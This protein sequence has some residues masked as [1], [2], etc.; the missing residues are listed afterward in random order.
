MKSPVQLSGA[1]RRLGLEPHRLVGACIAALGLAL[2]APV[3]AAPTNADC[4][5]CHDDA[6]LKKA[7]GTLVSATHQALAS[8]VHGTKAKD[9]V[10]CVGCHNDVGAAW[11][12]PHKT[13]PAPATCIGCHKDMAAK[14]PFHPQMVEDPAVIA[15]QDCHGGHDVVPVKDAAFKF[16]RA[17]QAEAC[18][19]CHESMRDDFK[20]SEHFKVGDGGGKEAPG[21]VA[22]HSLALVTAPQ[23]SKTAALKQNQVRICLGCHLD[24][25]EVRARVI[26]SAGFIREYEES[27]HGRALAA[28][29]EKAPACSDCHG[30]HDIKKAR[31]D[32]SKVNRFHMQEAC[33]ECHKEVAAA[34]Q[35]SVHG[36]ALAKGMKDAPTC[37]TCHGEHDIKKKGDPAS[38]VASA[39]LSAK[40]CAPCH[41][42]LQLAA[43]FSIPADRFQTFEDSFHGMA[44]RGGAAKVANCASCHGAHDIKPSSDP[45]SSVSK[46][47]LAATCGKCHPGANERFG[48]G[49]MHVTTS[50]QQPVLFW[51]SLIYILLIVFVIGAMAA[52][53]AI[54]FWRKSKNMMAVRRGEHEEPPAVH[55][56]YLRM[57]AG[58]RVQHIGLAVSFI[59]LVITG[60]MVRF[61]ES[62][63][64]AYIRRMSPA[65]FDL[66]AIAHR[67][68]AVVMLLTS[69]WHLGYI[70][71]TRRGHEFVRD[72]LPGMR[73]VREALLM[74]VYNL[75]WSHERPK[76]GRFCYVEK[77]EYW[78]LIWGTIVMTVT[79][80]VMWFDN[81]SINIITKL[82]YDVARMFHYYEA[83]LAT[84]A[85]AVWH[86]YAV[87]F[88][89]TVYPMNLSWITGML[90]ER[91]MEEEHPRELAE[92][93]EAEKK[94]KGGH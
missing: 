66:R 9:K 38:H 21:C 71:F 11:T 18:G 27:V 77:A 29:K 84:L 76:L 41:D 65:V 83:W 62:W 44:G 75:G 19:T 94:E 39:T 23:G 88:S 91:E 68:S 17:R 53:N 35:A 34:F 67:C 8:S 3:H 36:V 40:V 54:D 48:V 13:K 37:T 46:Q 1:S 28:G 7:D 50:R 14:H 25:P 33:A 16:A 15:C 5:K 89:P 81:Q 74:I 43:K 64:V 73:D 56:M 4:L 30:G 55:R 82:G 69:L 57:T 85:I 20:T 52:H 93:K 60:F 45:T 42:S 90:S 72:M 2:S 61:P 70:T 59:L 79:G 92:I 87:M 86:F 78:A 31:D 58:E 51:V 12:F 47:N 24:S 80:L 32:T 6:K 22:C 49:A 63:W 26:P 10:D